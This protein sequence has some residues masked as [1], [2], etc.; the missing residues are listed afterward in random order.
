MNASKVEQVEVLEL[1]GMELIEEVLLNN[2]AGGLSV[3][4]CECC[5][6]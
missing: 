4:P 6:G 3:P 2:I 5:C 1:N